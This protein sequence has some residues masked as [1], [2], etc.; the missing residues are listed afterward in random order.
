VSSVPGYRALGRCPPAPG[1]WGRRRAAGWAAHSRSS[2]YLCVTSQCRSPDGVTVDPHP[3]LP[4]A[5]EMRGWPRSQNRR[6]SHQPTRRPGGGGS[7]GGLAYRRIVGTP[8]P[9]RGTNHKRPLPPST[10][11]NSTPTRTPEATLP[12]L[13]APRR[14]ECPRHE[15]PLPRR[16]RLQSVRTRRSATPTSGTLRRWC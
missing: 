5:A 11:S 3:C 8:R 12:R 15:Q 2:G 6:A 16:W 9:P 7:A 10:A 14:R 13:R 1:R 4:R